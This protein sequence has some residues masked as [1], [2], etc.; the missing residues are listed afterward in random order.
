M[1][2][3]FRISCTEGKYSTAENHFM[4]LF[5][6]Y[7]TQRTIPVVYLFLI[8][9]ITVSVGTYCVRN[10]LNRTKITTTVKPDCASDLAITHSHGKS[11]SDKLYMAELP[12]ESAYL[13]PLKENLNEYIKQK[14]ESKDINSASVYILKLNSGDWISINDADK[15]QSSGYFRLAM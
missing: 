14:Q 2:V 9:L 4:K 7:V 5:I 6:R 10:Y 8:V 12:K 3:K 1:N 11:M 13:A 15:Y